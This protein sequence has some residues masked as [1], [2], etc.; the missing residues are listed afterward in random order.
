[1]LNSTACSLPWPTALPV[2]HTSV[3][4]SPRSLYAR[5]ME[6]LPSAS[7]VPLAEAD[8]VSQLSSS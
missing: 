5:S 2:T 8:W 3:A 7:V 4:W 6:A 1:M